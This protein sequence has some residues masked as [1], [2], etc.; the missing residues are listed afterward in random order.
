MSDYC[1]SC[2]KNLKNTTKFHTTKVHGREEKICNECYDKDW[3]NVVLDE[4][5]WRIEKRGI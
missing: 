5:W 4:P 1:Y 2:R 3:K